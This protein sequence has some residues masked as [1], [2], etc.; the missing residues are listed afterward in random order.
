M[1]FRPIPFLAL[2]VF[3][4]SAAPLL[5]QEG[6]LAALGPDSTVRTHAGASFKSTRVINGHSLEVLPH[7]VLDFRIS[8]RMGFVSGGIS[9]FFG[10]DQASIRLG[11]DYGLTDRLMVGIGRGS[12]RKTVDGFLKYKLLRQCQAG[13]T[14]PVTLDL[15]ASA[16]AITTVADQLP[17][18]APGRED[19]FSNRLA[20]SFQAV[21]GRKISEGISLQVMPGVVHRNL[22]TTAAERNDL[23]NAGVAGRAKVTKRVAITGEYY[24]VFPDQGLR[25]PYLNSLAFGVDIETG[26]HVFQ[27]QFTNSTGMSERDFITESTG[28]FF[29]GDIHFGFNISRVFT[30]HGPKA[31]HQG[32]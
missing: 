21:L 24:Y 15:V 31:R 22:V 9:E 11:L 12:F 20:Y 18:Y 6:L 28:D 1:L 8:H 10:L 23:L 17:W 29:D 27:L 2:A 7:G 5:A 4:L 25:Q 16:S 30:L 13:C 19:L 14:M 3:L 26:G 32:N